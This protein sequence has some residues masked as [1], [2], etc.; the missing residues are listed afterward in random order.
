MQ[1]GAGYW[2]Q[3][4]LGSQQTV[5]GSVTQGRAD[6]GGQWPGSYTL[7]SSNDGSTW[8]SVTTVIG[9]AGDNTKFTG[10]YDSNT[11]STNVVTPPVAARYW[12][13]TPGTYYG[14]TCLRWNVQVQQQCT[15]C[16]AGRS[17]VAG[18]GPVL[19]PAGSYCPPGVSAP[20]ASPLGYHSLAGASAPTRCAAGSYCPAGTQIACPIGSFCGSP[21]LSAVA[22]QCY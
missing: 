22:Q 21:G 20:T 16:P 5:V 3:I 2:L 6:V 4:D 1:N 19:C 8:T 13:Y 14:Y 7:Q 12:R 18:S 10:N 11:R 17:C 15:A 9:A